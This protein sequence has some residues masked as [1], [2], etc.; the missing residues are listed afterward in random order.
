M[1]EFAA[2]LRR[3]PE[4]G[5]WFNVRA[6]RLVRQIDRA[7]FEQLKRDP[8]QAVANL[9]REEGVT[10][11]AA[12]PPHPDQPE[13]G[14]SPEEYGVYTA[15]CRQLDLFLFNR[16]DTV[17]EDQTD[18]D[19]FEHPLTRRRLEFDEARRE[20]RVVQ[21]GLAE[22]FSEPFRRWFDRHPEMLSQYESRNRRRWALEKRFAVEN[23][24]R[25]VS[26]LGE[27]EEGAAQ[28]AF[29]LSRVGFSAEGRFALVFIRY[30]VTCSY[31]LV[32][33]RS[34][35]SWDRAEFIGAWVT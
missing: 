8:Q 12:E 32:F 11:R 20:Y 33:E 25:L 31:Y 6:G 13:D 17:F 18:G 21:P 34:Q 14:V 26:E 10:I 9:L 4:W 29:C 7:R 1:A 3:W 27:H 28:G 5:S 22:Q 35:M 2:G 19:M 24:Y 23:G 16:P 30:A 15:V